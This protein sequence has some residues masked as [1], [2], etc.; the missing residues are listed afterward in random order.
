MTKILKNNWQKFN[1][2]LAEHMTK[3][4]ALEVVTSGC[5]YLFT[6]SD[7][8]GSSMIIALGLGLKGWQNFEKR[9]EKTLS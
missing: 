3:F 5:V 1:K 2:F 9:K 8:T 4:L 6:H 7:P